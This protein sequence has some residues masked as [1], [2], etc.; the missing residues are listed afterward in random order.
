MAKRRDYD[1]PIYAD[2]RNKVYGRDNHSCQMPDCTSR[3]SKA[4][5]NA[6]HIK[7]W[8][9]CHWLRYEVRNGI[10]LCWTCHK[11]VTGSEEL[12]EGLFM[13]IVSNNEQSK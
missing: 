6:H 12:Y 5:L 1:D 11:R 2:W 4:R 3:R 10:T 8:A 13:H 9:D 7:R